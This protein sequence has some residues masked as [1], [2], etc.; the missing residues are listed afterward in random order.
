[1]WIMQIALGCPASDLCL[2]TCN[3]RFAQSLYCAVH[4]APEQFSRVGGIPYKAHLLNVLLLLVDNKMLR[5]CF[6]VD[7]KC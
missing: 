1:M 3:V 6:Q 2:I 7:Q 5:F 4:Y